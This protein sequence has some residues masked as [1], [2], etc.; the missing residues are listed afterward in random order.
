MGLGHREQSQVGKERIGPT[1][2]VGERVPSPGSLLLLAQQCAQPAPHEAVHAVE[3]PRMS[4]LEVA[5][6]ALAHGVQF[7]DDAAQ[8]VFA[9][10]PCPGP[11]TTAYRFQTLAP[12]PALSRLEVIAQEVEA[13][14]L[15]PTIPHVRLVRVENQS[16]RT[17]ASSASG[18]PQ[19]PFE[20]IRA[21]E[22]MGGG[23]GRVCASVRHCKTEEAEAPKRAADVP[24]A[25][26]LG[27]AFQFHW[28][29]EYVSGGCTLRT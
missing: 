11:D 12:H 28:R 23:Y 1:V 21:Q 4:V 14:V 17:I 6:R 16:I 5:V 29:C 18:V 24:L 13:L 10:A 25:F 9:C 20:A 27:E 8:T 2:R 19:A 3:G 22:A 15:L 7:C 26:E